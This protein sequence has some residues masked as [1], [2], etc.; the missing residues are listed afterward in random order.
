MC[1]LKAIYGT[2]L[3]ETSLLLHVDQYTAHY[4]NYQKLLG[5]L[6]TK[7]ILIFDKPPFT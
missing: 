7:K 3:L 6:Y 2:M 4:H 1:I 5:L